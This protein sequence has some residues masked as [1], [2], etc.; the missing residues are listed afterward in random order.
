LGFVY[1]NTP[2]CKI[3]ILRENWTSGDVLGHAA[4]VWGSKSHEFLSCPAGTA[5]I[6]PMTDDL[7]PPIKAWVSLLSPSGIRQYAFRRESRTP[8][9]TYLESRRDE[10]PPRTG[11]VQELDG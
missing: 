9:S 10:D 7:V 4:D 8:F 6:L 3:L 5:M 1:R 11:R 2:K